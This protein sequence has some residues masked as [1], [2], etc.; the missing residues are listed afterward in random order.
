MTGEA[1]NGGGE[2]QHSVY[3]DHRTTALEN[4]MMNKEKNKVLEGWQ[5]WQKNR[6]IFW[7]FF[8]MRGASKR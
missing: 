2:T 4:D 3:E 6:H 5:G 1:E 7:N 8:R